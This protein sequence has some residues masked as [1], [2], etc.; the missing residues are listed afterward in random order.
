MAKFC[1]KASED[2]DAFLHE[3]EEHAAYF[4]W[5]QDEKAKGIPL[6]LKDAAK[7]FYRGLT[8][9]I[10]SD[11]ESI[12]SVLCKKYGIT[13]AVEQ[14]SLLEYNQKP[15][16]AIEDYAAEIQKRLT[17]ANVN[18]S[19]YKLFIFMRGLK[20]QIYRE[21]LKTNPTT[22]SEAEDLAKNVARALI[23]CP[24]NSVNEIS[25]VVKNIVDKSMGEYQSQMA[26]KVDCLINELQPPESDRNQ[27]AGNNRQFGGDLSFKGKFNR[28]QQ[29]QNRSFQGYNGPQR[30]FQQNRNWGQNVNGNF[31][32]QNQN[33]RFGDDR[34]PGYRNAKGEYYRRYEYCDN[35]VYCRDC[36][37][38]H[39]VGRHTYGT[40]GQFSRHLN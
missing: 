23:R 14:H 2:I 35:T 29:G 20:P 31:N 27:F 22:I 38:R 32:R 30:N 4:G 33:F 16:E 36:N 39:P 10:K 5:S 18:D 11:F 6:V 15:E 1:G 24:D 34:S 40:N 12:K 21:V 7:V 19:N 28:G 13:H 3:F 37:A 9:E 8:A 25:G 17:Q 26:D